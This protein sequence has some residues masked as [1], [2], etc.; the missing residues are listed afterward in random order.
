MDMDDIQYLSDWYTEIV[1][2]ALDAAGGHDKLLA[3]IVAADMEFTDLLRC[4]DTVAKAA[5]A[6]EHLVAQDP[7]FQTD[8]HMIQDELAAV[9]GVPKSAIV[10]APYKPYWL[11]EPGWKK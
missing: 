9:L 5:A 8:A 6:M 3:D 11:D 4:K 1:A 7:S 2:Q 10:R